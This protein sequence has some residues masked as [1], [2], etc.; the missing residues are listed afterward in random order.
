MQ[1]KYYRSYLPKFSK[2][3]GNKYDLAYAPTLHFIAIY[4]YAV[5]CCRSIDSH[6]CLT[7]LLFS[8]CVDNRQINDFDT[9]F[10]NTLERP[11]DRSTKCFIYFCVNWS[12]PFGENR[13]MLHVPHRA[14]NPDQNHV[15]MFET[16]PRQIFEHPSKYRKTSER[17]RRGRIFGCSNICRDFL[18]CQIF[19]SDVNVKCKMFRC[20]SDVFLYLDGCSNICWG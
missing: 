6:G 8:Y 9:S 17:L 19:E 1:N 11:S 2:I 12:S 16:Y 7:C 4:F 20:L 10:Y 15:R 5:T 3:R 18:E 14:G 13:S